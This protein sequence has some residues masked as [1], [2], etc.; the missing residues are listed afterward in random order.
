MSLERMDTHLAMIFWMIDTDRYK[1]KKQAQFVT[2]E[3]AWLHM[4][5]NALGFE[6]FLIVIISWKYWYLTLTF[7]M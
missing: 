1:W 4:P 5:K 3:Q 6:Y 7:L 2:F